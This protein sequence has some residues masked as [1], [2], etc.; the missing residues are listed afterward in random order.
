MKLPVHSFKSLLIHVR[1]DLGRRNIGVAQHFLNN[2][3]IGAIAEQVG[4][5]AVPEKVRINILLQPGAPR[6]FFHDL[7]DPRRS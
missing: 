1:I 4:R 3:Q 7:P 6:V 2:A 5:E